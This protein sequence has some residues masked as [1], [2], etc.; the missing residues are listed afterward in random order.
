M[1]Q[2]GEGSSNYC[3]FH[4]LFS[5]NLPNMNPKP[6]M[7]DTHICSDWGGG[8]HIPT[9]SCPFW[10]QHSTQIPVEYQYNVTFTFTYYISVLCWFLNTLSPKHIFSSPFGLRAIRDPVLTPTE[11]P[12]CASTDL[13]WIK[14]VDAGNFSYKCLI[15]H[16]YGFLKGLEW[17]W[18]SLLLLSFFFFLF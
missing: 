6:L 16:Y 13:S 14:Q 2:V 11:R 17:V 3:C 5:A 1:I 4:R 8:T 12:G 10:K 15:V 9:L 18:F 7:G